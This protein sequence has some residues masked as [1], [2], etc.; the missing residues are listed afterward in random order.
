MVKNKTQDCGDRAFTLTPD[1]AR[2]I[3]LMANNVQSHMTRDLETDMSALV[4]MDDFKGTTRFGE[5]WMKESVSEWD[6]LQCIKTKMRKIL[7]GDK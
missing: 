7:E 6:M 3:W 5:Q 4:R 2:R 1:E